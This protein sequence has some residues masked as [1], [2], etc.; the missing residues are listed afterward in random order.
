MKKWLFLAFVLPL[1]GMQAPV[2]VD[3]NKA[4]LSAGPFKL[5]LLLEKQGDQQEYT[6]ITDLDATVADLRTQLNGVQ[7]LQQIIFTTR[8]WKKIVNEDEM[9][10]VELQPLF[11]GQREYRKTD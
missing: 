6:I 5:R 4:W 7:C 9:L 1:C 3:S 10:L 2:Y 8:A 11:F